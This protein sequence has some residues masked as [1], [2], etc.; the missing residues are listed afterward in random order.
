MRF[1]NLPRPGTRDEIRVWHDDPEA[2]P[3]I[4]SLLRLLLD[5]DRRG[6]DVVVLCIG[7]DRS[8]GD[9]LGPLV[10]RQLARLNLPGVIVIGTLDH[11]VHAT[12]LRDTLEEMAKTCAGLPVIAVDACLGPAENVG[13]ITL[14]RGPLKPGAGVNKAL[15]P[16][17]DLFI[18][19][20]VNVGG[21][22]EYLVLQNTRLSLVMRMAETIAAGVAAALADASRATSSGRLKDGN[23]PSSAGSV[24]TMED[25]F[26][27]TARTQ[28]EA[29]GGL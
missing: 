15:P 8:T 25:R 29:R 16:V 22:L 5:Q 20:T 19:G 12:N 13:S 24:R 9:S 4:A 21:A 1:C 26:R 14:G 11:P 2:V 6:R 18:T 10:G 7:T 3:R 23:R 27:P 17:G 28:G